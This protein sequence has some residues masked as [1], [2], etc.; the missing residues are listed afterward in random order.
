MSAASPAPTGPPLRRVAYT[1]TVAQSLREVASRWE[2]V[3]ALTVRDLKVRYRR[4]VLG[5]L[6]SLLTPLLQMAILYF[7]VKPAMG[8]NYPNISVVILTGVVAWGFFESALLDCTDCIIL[9]RDLVKKIYFPRP[10]LPLSVV[11]GNLVHF[12]LSFVVLLLWFLAAVPAYRPT[13][14]FFYLIPVVL[15]QVLF[16]SGLGLLLTALHTFYHDIKFVLQQLLR[17]LFFVS[18]VMFPADLVRAKLRVGV[19]PWAEH[20]Y[21]INPAATTIEAYRSILIAHRP[22]E[23]AYFLPIAALALLIFV[24]GYHLFLRASWRFP[25][26]I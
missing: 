3:R 14:V 13:L 7:V 24:L 26:A 10:A 1:E 5:F 8:L 23:M 4:S 20:L 22:P 17:I 6:W 16:V 21:M 18:G 25:E 12:A 15:V 11:L 19:G 9:N 2:L